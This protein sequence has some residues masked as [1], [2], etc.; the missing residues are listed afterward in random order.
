MQSERR[1]D[2]DREDGGRRGVSARVVTRERE[3]TF[4]LLLDTAYLMV[5]RPPDVVG[6]G[7]VDGEV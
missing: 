2:Y 4:N 6:R 7:Q 3:I 1:E 5:E